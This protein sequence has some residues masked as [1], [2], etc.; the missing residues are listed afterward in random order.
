MVGLHV[1]PHL[2]YDFGRAFQ[3]GVPCDDLTA[4]LLGQRFA[5]RDEFCGVIDV[6]FVGTYVDIGAHRAWNFTEKLLQ[7]RTEN[8]HSLRCGHAEAE[9]FVEILA[10]AGHVYLGN[11]HDTAGLRVGNNVAYLVISVIFSLVTAFP[12]EASVVQLRSEEHTSE[13]QSRQYLVCRLL[14]EKK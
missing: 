11:D 8:L 9:G 3:S 7:T 2:T 6:Y 13:L 12:L 14:L 1:G 5:E 10:V 4:G